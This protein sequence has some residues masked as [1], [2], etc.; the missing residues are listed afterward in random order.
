MIDPRF[1]NV[2]GVPFAGG[3]GPQPV[4]FQHHHHHHHHRHHKNQKGAIDDSPVSRDESIHKV[5]HGRPPYQQSKHWILN[6]CDSYNRLIIDEGAPFG[7]GYGVP[8]GAAG[9]FYPQQQQFAGGNYGFSN[10]YQGNVYDQ[11][12]FGGAATGAAGAPGGKH[13]RHH[14]RHHHHAAE[15]ASGTATVDQAQGVPE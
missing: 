3:Y 15:G 13:R 14:H 7:A 11:G 8:Y 4:P 2:G 9:A 5:D 6:S 1:A 12:Q 10:Q